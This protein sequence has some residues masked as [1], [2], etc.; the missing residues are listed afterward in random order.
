MTEILLKVALNTITVILNPFKYDLV[1]SHLLP[2]SR[3]EFNRKILHTNPTSYRFGCWFP[4]AL[5]NPFKELCQICL[6]KMLAE[7][8]FRRNLKKKLS[9]QT[10]KISKFWVLA[11]FL[12]PYILET[13]RTMQIY[14]YYIMVIL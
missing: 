14:I 5:F 12:P 6:K 9:N 2:Y 7:R 1:L 8:N 3:Q 4:L 13:V 11:L 10:F